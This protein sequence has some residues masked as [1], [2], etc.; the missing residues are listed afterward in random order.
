MPN[1]HPCNPALC[2][3][4][5]QPNGCAMAAGLAPQACW[6][7]RVTLSDQALAALPARDV[8]VRCICRHCGV[9]PGAGSGVDHPPI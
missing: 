3:L 5:H 6:C 1:P 9:G 4:C 8:G 2:P 7:M